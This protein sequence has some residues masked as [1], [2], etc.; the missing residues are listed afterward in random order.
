M[1]MADS[2]CECCK[3]ERPL[4]G[5]A[6]SGI[7]PISIAWCR[8]CLTNFAEPLDLVIALDQPGTF[9]DVLVFRNGKYEEFGA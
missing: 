1:T 2:V 7:A 5:V 8:E 6:S 3:R 9:A 4:A